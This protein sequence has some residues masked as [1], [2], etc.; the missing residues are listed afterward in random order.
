M[1]FRVYLWVSQST[2]GGVPLYPMYGV[3][4]DKKIHYNIANFRQDSNQVIIYGYVKYEVYS[5][6]KSQCATESAP[7]TVS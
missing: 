1:L 4:W 3:H 5:A 2:P 6:L 7:F